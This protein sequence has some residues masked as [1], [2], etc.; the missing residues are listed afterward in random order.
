MSWGKGEVG[1]NESYKKELI[2][3]VDNTVFFPATSKKENAENMAAAQVYGF[4]L[5]YSVLL[6]KQK[7]CWLFPEGRRVH[8]YIRPF[9]DV[10][11]SE[12]S[13]FS[14]NSPIGV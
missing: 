8:F 12:V 7:N 4:F 6:K 2:Q 14:Q 3:T 10:P 13:V 5:F 9:S 1:E 11:V